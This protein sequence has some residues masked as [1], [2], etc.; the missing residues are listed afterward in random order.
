MTSF[1]YRCQL[2]RK[3]EV[4]CPGTANF[5]V[6]KNVILSKKPHCHEP[7]DKH[8][9]IHNF[10]KTVR[11]QCEKQPGKSNKDTFEE[12]ADE[13]VK[14]NPTIKDSDMSFPM[15][16]SSCSKRVQNQFP[17]IPHTLEE[18]C[19]AI[20]N[21]M[22][23]PVLRYY[24]QTVTLKNN[25]VCGLIFGRSELIEQFQKSEHVGQDGTFKTT[26]APFKQVFIIMYQFMKH[27]FPAFVCLMISKKTVEYFPMFTAIYVNQ[28][29]DFQASHI[30]Q[31][32]EL[33]S[34]KASK[35]V[36]KKISEENPL[37]KNLAKCKHSGCVFHNGSCILANCKKLGLITKYYYSI[38]FKT[39]VRRLMLLCYLP[40]DCIETTWNL[41]LKGVKFN[42]FDVAEKIQVEKFKAYFET[43]WINN[44]DPEFLSIFQVDVSTNNGNENFNK[45]CNHK[46][47]ARP[48]LW[49]FLDG[50]NYLLDLSVKDMNR[51]KAGKKI[52]RN[53][54]R[55]SEDNIKHREH[56]EAMLLSG[57]FDEMQFIDFLAE[58][59]GT[60][61]F[62][63]IDV[64][65]TTE[66]VPEA[67]VVPIDQ[68]L[69]QSCQKPR[70]GQ[71]WGM[72]HGNPDS[73]EQNKTRTV[74]SQIC[75][76]CKNNIQ[77]FDPC[78]QCGEPVEEVLQMF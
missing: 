47:G 63:T 13:F 18:V 68:N 44:T 43:Q 61:Y 25:Q 53:V 56:A 35:L 33:A 28:A 31:D 5:D 39:W 6:N 40:A 8:S 73:N 46:I 20:K 45:K 50:M 24:R 11:N 23:K 69:C 41:H 77:V 70:N 21:N 57:A 27:W 17:N 12:M 74:H 32:Y 10:F 30:H 67:E 62:K 29:P 1:H 38:P 76:E 65:D 59:L 72:V 2:N 26:P 4:G 14:K 34:L 9:L 7:N 48:S 51:L 66:A 71:N 19:D 58:N 55:L 49:K 36:L 78:P 52:V 3:K 75:T 16:E 54:P 15:I 22:D 37:R 64:E 60:K 42:S